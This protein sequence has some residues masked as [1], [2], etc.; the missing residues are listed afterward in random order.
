MTA[1]PRC[2][3]PPVSTRMQIRQAV[4]RIFLN[5]CQAGHQFYTRHGQLLDLN[6]VLRERAGRA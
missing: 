3:Q 4:G 2:A 1:C 6:R 5:V